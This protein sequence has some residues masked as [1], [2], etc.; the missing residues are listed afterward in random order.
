[1]KCLQFINF[2]VPV[3]LLRYFLHLQL[4]SLIYFTVNYS[5]LGMCDVR[6][7]GLPVYPSC[8]CVLSLTSSPLTN[9][10][11]THL[12]V[13]AGPKGFAPFSNREPI[14][15]GTTVS[16]VQFRVDP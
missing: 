5:R 16:L 4:T 3:S 12:H 10:Y 14:L 15:L 9:R 6:H 13:L 1:M 8:S 7:F 11:D 2:K